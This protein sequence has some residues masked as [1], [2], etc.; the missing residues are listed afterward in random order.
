MS[1]AKTARSAGSAAI[2]VAAVIATVIAALMFVPGLLGLDRYVITGGSMSGTFDRG[3]LLFE[4]QVPVSDLRVG[5][6]ITYMPPSDSGLTELVTH[7]IVAIEPGDA[8]TGGPVF[9]TQGDANESADPW[10][11]TLA[12]DVQPRVEGW[13]PQVG[14]VFIALAEP[15]V[16][17][18][19][20]GVPAAI[21]ALL[22]LRDLVRAIRRR[23]EAVIQPANEIL[24]APTPDDVGAPGSDVRTE[25]LAP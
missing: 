9:R 4:R 17:I 2:T 1:A 20:I 15:S 24:A 21:I 23:D 5:D 22:S 16:R 18:I 12:L 6:I 10:T 3:A 19:A 14:W 13:L 8:A 11:F 25:V 7:R